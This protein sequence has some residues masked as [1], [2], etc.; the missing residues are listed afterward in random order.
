MSTSVCW[1]LTCDGLVSRPVK[2]S[3]PLNTTVTGDKRPVP[4]TTYARVNDLASI[5]LTQQKLEISAGSMGHLA[6]K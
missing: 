2:D 1:K 6:R 3:H 5:Y 4:W